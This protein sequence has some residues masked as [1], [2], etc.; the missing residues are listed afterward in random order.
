MFSLLRLIRG[1]LH[2]PHEPTILPTFYLV[3]RKLL[4]AGFMQ[5]HWRRQSTLESG[6]SHR[7]PHFV[8]RG[9]AAERFQATLAGLVTTET[10]TR[11]KC[12]E[13]GKNS[14][15]NPNFFSSEY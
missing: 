7:L 13:T 14:Q 12:A 8:L 11:S 9:T 6:I 15:K 2:F 4:P 3:L 5:T 10:A 1:S